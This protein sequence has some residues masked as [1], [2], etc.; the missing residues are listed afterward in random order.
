MAEKIVEGKRKKM[1]QEARKKR[2]TDDDSDPIAEPEPFVDKELVINQEIASIKPITRYKLTFK[3]ILFLLF[4]NKFLHHPG[5]CKSYK[6]SRR[7]PGWMM[8]K[9]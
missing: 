5:T 4:F 7:S 1:L 6:L 8:R 3:H 2:K 9:S